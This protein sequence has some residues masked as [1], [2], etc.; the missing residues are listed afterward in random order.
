[1]IFLQFEIRKFDGSPQHFPVFCHLFEQ[2]INSKPVDESVKMSRLLQLLE[3]PP[4]EAVRR[5]EAVTGGPYQS[6]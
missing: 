5:Y 1:M 2:M 6:T 4:L 3:G